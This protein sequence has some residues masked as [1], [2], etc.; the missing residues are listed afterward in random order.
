[1]GLIY[2][3]EGDNH[4]LSIL[5]QSKIADELMIA[6]P[7]CFPDFS[8]FA[9]EIFKAGSIKKLTFITTL[10]QEEVYR[11]VA[12]LISLIK[13]M[14][15]VGIEVRMFIDNSLHGKVY[16]FKKVGTPISAVITSANLTKNGMTTNHEWGYQI[17]DY[18][19]IIFLEKQLLS[20][21][22]SELQTEALEILN[23]R[24]KEKPEI[25]VQKPETIELD[26]VLLGCQISYSTRFFVKP[27]GVT[28]DPVYDGDFSDEDKQYFSRRPNAVRIGDILIAYGVGSRKII[29]AFKV[30]SES[31]FTGNPDDRWKWYV[32]VQN[33]TPNM[34]KIW[35][36]RDLFIMEIAA[37]Y[38]EKYSLN[39][40]ANGNTN[41]NG[42]KRQN[43][44][45]RLADCFGRYLYSKVVIED[46]L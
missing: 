12:S 13:E 2:N 40:T 34:G 9:Y 41:L 33:L 32:K 19:T 1:M 20:E 28:D 30:L 3:K 10:K 18:E 15:R 5:S 46:T 38:Y 24:I 31:I 45:I 8:F 7:F 26:D 23:K 4:F 11:K 14:N 37:H 21:V 35:M 44:K 36:K 17:D 16:I 42:L 39:V 22:K 29:S 6:S 25:M 43:D 27:L